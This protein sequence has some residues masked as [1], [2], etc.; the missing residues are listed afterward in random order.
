MAEWKKVIVSGSSAELNNIFASGAITGSDISSSGDLFASLS[1]SNNTDYRTV[2]VDPTTGR[3]YQTGSYG[4]GGGGIFIDRGTFYNTQNTLQ[5]TGSTLQSSPS[6][7]GT[8]TASVSTGTSNAIYSFLTSESIYSFNHNVGYPNANSWKVNLQ[9]SYFNNFDANTNVSEVLRFIAGLLSQSAPDASPNTKTF[10]GLNPRFINTGLLTINGRIPSQST[11]S[12]VLYLQSKGFA[13]SGSQSFDGFGNI[14]SASTFAI[15]YSSSA[16]GNGS[17]VSSSNDLQLF[18]LGLKTYDVSI[19]AS[20]TFKFYSSSN[21]TVTTNNSSSQTLITL[22]GENASSGGAI[23]R[24]ISTTN[25]AVIPSAYQDGK[26][27]GSFSSSYNPVTFD[28]VTSGSTGWYHFSQSIT[29]YTGSQTLAEGVGFITASRVFRSAYLDTSFPANVI[30][31]TQTTTNLTATSRSLSG[32]PYLSQSTYLYICTSSGVFNPLYSTQ[33][34]ILSTTTGS[35]FLSRSL[36]SITCSINTNGTIGTSNIVYSSSG[37]P[38][39]KSTN[40]YPS[41][42][43]VIKVSASFALNPPAGASGSALT[44]FIV[45]NTG[46]FIS[47]SAY[48]RNTGGTTGSGIFL[49]YFTP[50]TFGQPVASG[51]MAL[52]NRPQGFDLGTLVDSSNTGSELFTG[53]SFRIKITDNLLSGS[54]TRG[55][56]FVTGAFDTSALAPTDLQVKPGYLVDPGGQY[57]Y[58]ITGSATSNNKYYARAFQRAAN[59]TSI[60][61]NLGKTLINWDDDSNGVAAVLIFSSSA[62]GSVV[63]TPR[64]FDPTETSIS[65]LMSGSMTT[66]FKNPFGI[67]IDLFGNSG[68]SLDGTTYTMIL[69]SANEMLL[70]GLNYK[71]FILLIRYKGDPLP[72][73]GAIITY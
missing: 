14:Y 2:V 23:K 56:K 5:I 50:G 53:E 37:S 68:G 6:S 19:S 60:K 43:D 54:Y 36:N 67:P 69:Y 25:P 48:S 72:V 65:G 63:G 8:G 29:I 71:D 51:T 73:S 49:N 27:T 30:T 62:I 33:T 58:W 15:D 46:S 11:N 35:S 34:S 4:G 61:I 55:D 28:S 31:H 20:T 12:D 1:I 21:E 42:N 13:N 3:L 59:I 45:S 32:A 38:T 70:N 52:Y 9:G 47:S 17:G 44:S 57:R 22:S 64:I 66:S 7:S 24:T 39:A 16:A 41:Q 26:F 10:G 40:A 18:G